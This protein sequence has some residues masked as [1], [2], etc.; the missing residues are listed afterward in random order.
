MKR[1]NTLITVLAIIG[2]VAFVAGIAYAVYRFFIE[3][4]FERLCADGFCDCCDDFEDFGDED[5]DDLEGF[6]LDD[7]DDET[8]A[9]TWEE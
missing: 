1:D 6:I 8:D 5:F 7:E 2:A 9:E 4:D 3:R